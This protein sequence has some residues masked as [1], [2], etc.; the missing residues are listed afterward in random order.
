MRR[1]LS[2]SL[3]QEDPDLPGL[4][5]SSR[6]GQAKTARRPRF[7]VRHSYRPYFEP[8]LTTKRRRPL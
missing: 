4:G 2:R 3:P 6:G 7:W 1:L 8:T 5:D